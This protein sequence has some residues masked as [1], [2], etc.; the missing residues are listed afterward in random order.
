MVRPDRI[1]GAL[2]AVSAVIRFSE[3]LTDRDSKSQW[4]LTVWGHLGLSGG[5]FG[6]NA[7]LGRA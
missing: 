2:R 5:R 6:G 1:R 4:I 7:V 3:A